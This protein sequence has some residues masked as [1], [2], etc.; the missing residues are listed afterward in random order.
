MVAKKYWQLTLT[1]LSQSDYIFITGLGC[2][3][4][5]C[6]EDVL[7]ISLSNRVHYFKYP[8]HVRVITTCE[9]QESMLKL[10][11]GDSIFRLQPL[12][13]KSTL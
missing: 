13:S 7:E 11:Y 5:V 12:R 2:E 6:S 1:E 9:K 4:K 3:L 10:K 8:P